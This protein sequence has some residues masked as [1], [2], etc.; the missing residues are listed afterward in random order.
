MLTKQ[1]TSGYWVLLPNKIEV[2]VY[3]ASAG[4]TVRPPIHFKTA[5]KRQ[6]SNEEAIEAGLILAP[7][8]TT[9]SLW[10]RGENYEPKVG[11]IIQEPS[12]DKWIAN[13]VTIKIFGNLFSCICVKTI[14]NI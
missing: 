13:G 2:D 5:R 1:S 7:G 8:M 3:P 11:D 14:G 9:F 4:E 12:G 6:T 10:D